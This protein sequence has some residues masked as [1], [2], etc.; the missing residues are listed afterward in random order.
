MG[1]TPAAYLLRCHVGFH[2]DA[3]D[4]SPEF[5]TERYS[6]RMAGLDEAGRDVVRAAVRGGQGRVM[7]PE[8]KRK[9]CLRPCKDVG[10]MAW[11]QVAHVS[12]YLSLAEQ[13]IGD[14]GG[15]IVKYVGS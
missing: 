13:L 14:A 7:S 15:G 9:W 5:V 2:I 11:N 12:P 8:F 3:R 1:L 4:T 6:T 10:H